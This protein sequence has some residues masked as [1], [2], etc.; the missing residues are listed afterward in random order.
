M[1]FTSFLLDCSVISHFSWLSGQMRY[2]SKIYFSGKFG[3]IAMSVLSEA[4]L[5]TINMD[6]GNT[7]CQELCS[8]SEDHRETILIFALKQPQ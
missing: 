5:I 3:I 8:K 2:C 7:N 1:Y 6:T 4:D